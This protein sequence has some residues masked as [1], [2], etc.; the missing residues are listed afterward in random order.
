VSIERQTRKDGR[1]VVRERCLLQISRHR[2]RAHVPDGE[3]DDDA[4]GLL[5]ELELAT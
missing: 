4:E 1:K 2:F 3:P 5:L